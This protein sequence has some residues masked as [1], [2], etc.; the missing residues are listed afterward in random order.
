MASE[1]EKITFKEEA[2]RPTT[3]FQMQQWKLKDNWMSF[4]ILEGKKLQPAIPYPTKISFK[5]EDK[6]YFRKYRKILSAV[7]PHNLKDM[8]WAVILD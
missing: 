2:F 3:D 5:R 6:I 8:L 1:N 7:D 4:Q